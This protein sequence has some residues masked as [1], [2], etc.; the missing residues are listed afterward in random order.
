MEVPE[1]LPTTVYLAG[2]NDR[3]TGPVHRSAGAT[4]FS[5]VKSALRHGTFGSWS[6]IGGWV[7]HEPTHVLK[8]T[9]TWEVE[10]L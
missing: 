2:C 10:E 1:N 7:R 6:Q 4:F 5:S 9:I 8:G 3:W